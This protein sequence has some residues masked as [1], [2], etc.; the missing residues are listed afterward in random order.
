MDKVFIIGRNPSNDGLSTPI[1]VNDPYNN[2]STNH[3]KITYDGANFYIE[4]LNSSNGTFV[5]G[6]KINTKTKIS[7]ENTILL[8]S[9]YV[10]NLDN[11]EFQNALKQPMRLINNNSNVINKVVNVPLIGG[12]IGILSESPV[13][14]L[15]KRIAQESLMAG[16]LF[17]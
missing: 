2:V 11:P 13:N 1:V 17:K 5:D 14:K 6:N 15:N 3:C 9:N 7:K 4:D 8:G 10:L 16:K 12:I